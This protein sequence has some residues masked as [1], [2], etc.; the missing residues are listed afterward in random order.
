MKRPHEMLHLN[1]KYG[2]IMDH[3]ID[4]VE[5]SFLFG[6]IKFDFEAKWHRKQKL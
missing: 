5:F 2:V 3:T 1:L 6:R 4:C